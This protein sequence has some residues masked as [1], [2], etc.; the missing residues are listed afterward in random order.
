MAKLTLGQAVRNCITVEK[1]AERFYRNLAAET[2]EEGVKAFLVDMAGQEREHAAAI[3]KFGQEQAAR[4]PTYADRELEI[5]EAAPGWAEVEDLSL[6]Q[7]FD[8]AI[9][10][11]GHAALYYDIIADQTEGDVSKFY[12]MLSKTEEK[13][14]ENL[15]ERRAG[16][17]A[18]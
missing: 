14:I 4:L 2:K 17:Q 3:E 5:V 11:E 13:H 6:E 7:A 1:A 15:Q 18:S 9:E 10:C 8:V 12:R 16:M